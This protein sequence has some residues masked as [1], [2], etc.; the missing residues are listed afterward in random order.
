[1]VGKDSILAVFASKGWRDAHLAK[2]IASALGSETSKLAVNQWLY[3]PEGLYS[4]DKVMVFDGSG[5]KAAWRPRSGHERRSPT[6]T[7]TIAEAAEEAG[8][9]SRP[10]Y[11][12]YIDLNN[13]QDCHKPLSMMPRSRDSFFFFS[14]PVTRNIAPAIVPGYIDVIDV[15]DANSGSILVQM[16]DAAV[17]HAIECPNPHVGVIIVTKSKLLDSLPSVLRRNHRVAHT[18]KVQGW[19]GLSSVLSA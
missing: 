6:Y 5:E 19:E 7:Q 2:D 13:V 4:M 3:S 17:T 1:M 15:R 16:V 9:F 11:R 18:R 14:T 10:S 8:F 12:V